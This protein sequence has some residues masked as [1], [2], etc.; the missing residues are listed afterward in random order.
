MA[1]RRRSHG[2]SEVITMQT[3]I[4]LETALTGAIILSLVSSVASYLIG[5]RCRYCEMRKRN[6]ALAQ[7]WPDREGAQD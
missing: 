4:T 3:Y 1:R 7:V 2:Q 6:M 5:R